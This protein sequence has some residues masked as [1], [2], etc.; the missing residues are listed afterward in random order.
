MPELPEVET[1]VRDLRRLN[2]EG[3]H[4]TSARIGWPRSVSRWSPAQFAARLRGAEIRSVHRRA[5]YIVMALSPPWTLLI[6]LR[7][8]GQLRLVADERPVTVHEHVILGLNDG[9][10]LRLHDPRKFA[11]VT[12][13][14]QP[15]SVL[16][17]LGPEPLARSFTARRLAEMLGGRK[18]LIKPLLLDQQFVA[19]IGNIYADESLW[20]A[21]LHPCRSSQDLTQPEIRRLHRSLRQVLRRAIANR[22]TSLADGEP[23]FRSA[24]GRRGRNAAG[25][26][27][28]RRTGA[29]CPRCG[30]P[31][32]RCVV[33]QRGTHLCPKCQPIDTA[34]A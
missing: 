33:A 20:S 10:E 15:E 11:R 23:N 14:D 5:K 26:A 25:L 18:R 30:G 21:R 8:T 3:T 1:V 12:L 2:I 4:F 32:Q 22:G 28:F 16:G 19:G 31:I 17:R 34:P 27:V 24:A 13:T 6:H 29:A 9:R 7:M